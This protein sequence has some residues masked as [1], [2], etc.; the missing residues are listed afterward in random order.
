MINYFNVISNKVN[1]L[2]VA[3]KYK[4]FSDRNGTIL[5]QAN[6]DAIQQH[7]K[8]ISEFLENFFKKIAQRNSIEII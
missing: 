5:N 3:L 4:S 2:D 6:F 1:K 8:T 7:E